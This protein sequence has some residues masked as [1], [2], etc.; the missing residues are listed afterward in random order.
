MKGFVISSF[1]S[2]VA[3]FPD[4]KFTMENAKN[5]ISEWQKLLD[6][7]RVTG[8]TPK[9]EKE[10]EKEDNKNDKENKEEKDNKENKE[11]KEKDLE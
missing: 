2:L 3:I 6:E 7:K 9:N 10:E 8:W 1:D 5:N 11:E 4:L